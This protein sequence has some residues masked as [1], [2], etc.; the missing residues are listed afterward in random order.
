MRK[1]SMVIVLLMVAISS[2]QTDGPKDPVTPEWQFQEARQFDFWVGEWDV[3][4]RRIQ[5]DNSW[6]D[7]KKSKAHIYRILNGRAILELWEEQSDDL[8]QNTI[9]GYS[10]RYYDEQLKKWVLCLNWPGVNR[11]GSTSLT[12]AFR[13]N[14]G[15]FFG[16]R[17]LSDSTSIISRYTFS[18]ITPKSLRWDDSFSK[19]DGKT[20]TNNWIMEFTRTEDLPRKLSGDFIHTFRK[21]ERCT[22]NEFAALDKLVGEWKGTVKRKDN[23]WVEE[24][25][26][27]NSYRSLGGCSVMAF[28]ETTGGSNVYKEFMLHTFNTFANKYEIGSLNNVT[29]STYLS[30]YGNLNNEKELVLYRL[31]QNNNT[32]AEIY[33]WVFAD[34]DSLT[35]EKW[36]YD[37]GSKVKTLEAVVTRNSS[38]N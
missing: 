16:S 17:P 21:G 7:W 27:L 5:D 20:W 14:R 38:E 8:P 2:G 1:I 6:V 18:D 36:A 19:D 22:R 25:T 29:S 30:Y 26:T 4:L 33:S 10:L 35:I 37:G 28:L 13:H 11:S 15:E 3:N 32:P 23:D 31:N 9:I 24:K 12:G 34:D